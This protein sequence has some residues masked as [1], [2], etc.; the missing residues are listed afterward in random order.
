[1]ES[2]VVADNLQSDM[3]L[4]AWALVSNSIHNFSVWSG[5]KKVADHR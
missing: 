2:L 3:I 4:A 5:T 1:M